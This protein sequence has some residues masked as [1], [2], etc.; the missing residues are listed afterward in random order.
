MPTS[1]TERTT[2]STAQATI[3]NRDQRK[4]LES[5]LSVMRY[6]IADARVKKV[7][8]PEPR[9]IKAARAKVKA[10][11]IA[12]DKVAERVRTACQ[13]EFTEVRQNAL[14]GAADK[15]LTLVLAL[16]KEFSAIKD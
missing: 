7:L 1:K 12:Q 14:F 13:R 5:R 11:D 3:L 9:D 6:K 10:W 8:K 15:A 16:E 4:H 2:M